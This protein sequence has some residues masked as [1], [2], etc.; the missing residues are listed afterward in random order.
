MKRV[1]GEPV[2]GVT[3][4]CAPAAPCVGAATERAGIAAIA[5]T[6]NN[7]TVRLIHAESTAGFGPGNHAR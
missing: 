1:V 6:T 7:A 5:T 3:V 4:I 2:A